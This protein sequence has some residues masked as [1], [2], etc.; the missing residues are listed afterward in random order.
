MRAWRVGFAFFIAG[1]GSA[2]AADWPPAV[3]ERVEAAVSNMLTLERPES[4]GLATVF[5]GNKYV[6]CRR[7]DDRAVRCEAGGSLLQPSLART[8]TS[9]RIDTLDAF[10]W[11]LDSSFGNY[12]E[13]FPADSTAKVL[14]AQIEV[15][16][17]EAYDADP[18]RIEVH[19]DWVRKEPCPPRMGMSMNQAGAIYDGRAM[20][21]FAIRACAYKPPGSGEF[22]F[23]SGDVDELFAAYGARVT[24]ELQRLRVNNDRLVWFILE[25]G[26]GFVQCASQDKPASQY[27]EAQSADSWPALASVLTPERIARLHGL[28]YADPGRSPNY[29]RT[30]PLETFDDAAIARDLLTI[31]HDVYGY[32]GTPRLRMA[33]EKTEN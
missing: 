4:I 14:A 24:G 17:S 18:E 29:W 1:M 6:Q 23:V 19:T 20:A 10:G 11:K 27:C 21:L 3:R 16:L 31:L 30:Y 26:I 15:A 13:T 9:A 2:A 32:R 28:G 8:L 22:H 7:Q 25:T 5:D 33:S 12:V